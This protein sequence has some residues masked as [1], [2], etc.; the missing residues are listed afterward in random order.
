MSEQ[1]QLGRF[2]L[3]LSEP[4]P[5]ASLGQLCRVAG[6]YGCSVLI[7]EDSLKIRV[8]GPEGACRELWTELE[9]RGVFD[10]F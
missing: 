6:S 2:D 7:M 9:R 1:P 4:M 3:A 5:D 10:V 8:M